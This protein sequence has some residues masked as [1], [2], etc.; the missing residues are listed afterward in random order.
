MQRC[1]EEAGEEDE[2]GGGGKRLIASGAGYPIELLMY[3]LQYRISTVTIVVVGD[4][5]FKIHQ[6]IAKRHRHRLHYR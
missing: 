2:K 3:R 5:F 1:P 4:I 6:I